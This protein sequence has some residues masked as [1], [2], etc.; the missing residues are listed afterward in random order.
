MGY[1]SA[2]SAPLSRR[3][4]RPMVLNGDRYAIVGILPDRFVTPVRDVDVIVPFVREEDPRR[5][6]RDARFM[7]LVGRLRPNVSRRRRRP[8]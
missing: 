7:R 5:E 3:S 1:G 8:T 4:A 6:V 2:A